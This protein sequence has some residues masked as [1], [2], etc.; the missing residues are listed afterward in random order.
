MNKKNRI[1]TSLLL[2]A[3]MLILTIP[4]VSAQAARPLIG[5]GLG[6]TTKHMTVF[7]DQLCKTYQG[8]LDDNESFTILD[9]FTDD[10]WYI[11]YSTASGEKSG[12][13]QA[14]DTNALIDYCNETGVCSPKGYTPVYYGNSASEYLR[15]GY[16]DEVAT[17][18]V[19][20]QLGEWSYIEYDTS[21]GRK[22]GYVY[23]ENLG[24]ITDEPEQ[25]GE[26]Y[27]NLP[28]TT[29]YIGELHSV[30]A[31]P[32]YRYNK[33]GSVSDMEITI[34]KD[35]T[36]KNAEYT[37]STYFIEYDVTGTAQKKTGFIFTDSP[38]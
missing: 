8:Y 9:K 18:V 6:C 21:N 33:V 26:F 5:S 29:K 13:I 25:Y 22:R 3:V 32:T 15:A 38:L 7:K 14:A 27:L 4:T 28:K 19:L 16:V 11:V 34:L 20:S 10:T 24:R 35:L 37:G 23:T 12:Y 2:I 17:V 31:G 30:Y 36:P 1:R